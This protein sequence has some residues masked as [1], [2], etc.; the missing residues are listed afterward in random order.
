[1]L[2]AHAQAEPIRTDQL[3]VA[4]IGAGATGVELAAQ[5]HNPTR[6]LV[7]YGFDRINPDEDI[8]LILI[9]AADRI[10]PALPTR[11]S[12][13]ATALLEKLGIHVRTSA[14]VAAV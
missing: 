9:E 1:F 3:D 5:L 6:A 8:K 12:E 2:R 10:L 11:L 14:K 7:S 13:G 4:I